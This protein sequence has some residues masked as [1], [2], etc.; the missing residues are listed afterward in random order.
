M[1]NSGAKIKRVPKVPK[2]HLAF[3]TRYVVHAACGWHFN[4]LTSDRSL[5][6]CLSCRRTKA[7]KRTP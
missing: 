7:F 1:I 3:E 4:H 5:V 2:V 6:T